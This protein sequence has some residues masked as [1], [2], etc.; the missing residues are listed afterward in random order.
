MTAPIGNVTGIL[1]TKV[2]AAI[3]MDPGL[4]VVERTQPTLGVVDF[5]DV[6]YMFTTTTIKRVIN[7]TRAVVTGAPPR[8]FLHVIVVAAATLCWMYVATSGGS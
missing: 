3:G 5:A 1:R 4:K 6:A 8:P 7:A 2:T